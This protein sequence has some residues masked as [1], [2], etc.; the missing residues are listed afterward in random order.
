MSSAD[1]WREGDID[2]RVDLVADFA[3]GHPRHVSIGKEIVG[4]P[5]RA[6]LAPD[7]GVETVWSDV[8]EDGAPVVAPGPRVSVIVGGGNPAVVGSYEGDNRLGRGLESIE[9]AK[10]PAHRL[11]K[12]IVGGHEDDVIHDVARCPINRS[13]TIR[14]RISR[15]NANFMHIVE[16]R[17]E[18]EDP[19]LF[20]PQMRDAWQGAS[21]IVSEHVEGDSYLA[22][23][24]GALRLLGGGS[25][26]PAKRQQ[27]GR[28][29][30]DNRNGCKQLDQREASALV[31]INSHYLN[32]TH[33]LAKASALR[34]ESGPVSVDC[35]LVDAES[36]FKKRPP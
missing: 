32:K 9:V 20:N 1:F 18:R 6:I 3:G 14:P 25:H 15:A 11:P 36:A 2:P 17:A 12:F 16:I 35:A 13:H 21:M 5:V 27:H 22:H 4:R 29:N 19:R 30:G 31:A 34:M 8:V 26:A 23:V 7:A 24:R 10:V 33:P 28:Q